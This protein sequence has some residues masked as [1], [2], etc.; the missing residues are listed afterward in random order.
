MPYGEYWKTVPR[1]FPWVGNRQ[2]ASL[3]WQKC[4]GDWA[5]VG[6][7]N[8]LAVLL[9]YLKLLK[10]EWPHVTLVYHIESDG[11]ICLC[12]APSLTENTIGPLHLLQKSLSLSGLV[13]KIL[14][15]LLLCHL[16]WKGLLTNT[17]RRST[18]LLTLRE[19]FT[20]PLVAMVQSLY[21][22]FNTYPV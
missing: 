12:Q 9:L 1:L 4:G 19:R 21:T 2:R 3:N 7:L 15:K 22:H 6:S 17:F 5:V 10:A 18:Y 16:F 13:T 11:T 14:L 20:C 8:S